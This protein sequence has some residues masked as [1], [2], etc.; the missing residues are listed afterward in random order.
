MPLPDKLFSALP[1]FALFF[2]ILILTQAAFGQGASKINLIKADQL[3]YNKDLGK[4]LRRVIGNVAFEHDGAYLYCDSAYFHEDANNV[5]AF[6][7]IHIKVSDTLNIYGD[8]L[9]YDGETK[10]GDLTGKVKLVDNQTI[11]LTDHLIWNRIEGYSYYNTGG[12]ITNKDNKLTSQIGYYYTDRKEFFF[13]KNVI[14]VNPKYTMKSD[15]LLYNTV[16]RTSFFKGPTTIK[17]ES[18]YIYCE[19]GWYN[20]IT[21]V[22]QF[23]KNGYMISGERKLWGDSLYY[24]RQLGLG[25]AFGNVSILDTVQDVVVKGNKGIYQELKGYVRMTDSAEGILVDKSGSFFLHADTLYATFD[26]ARQFKVLYAYNHTKF[27]RTDL[28][29]L[30]DSLVYNFGDSTILLHG[31]PVIWSEVNQLTADSIRMWMT[32]K[33]VDSMMLYNTSFIVSVSDTGQYDQIKGKNMIGHFIENELR[34]VKV[35]SNA[36]TIYFAKE[37][38]G[39]SIGV[40]FAKSSEMLIRMK[41]KKVY[42][43]KYVSEPDAYLNPLKETKAEEL[44][45]KGFQWLESRRPRYSGDIYKW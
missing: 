3:K 13:K 26:T 7:T 16:S 40:N 38:D 36:E 29:G 10:I 2:C 42:R 23:N 25:K 41:D 32:N 33:A 34:S 4:D 20:T 12:K 6:G 14:L 43:I 17:G 44:K 39:H 22:S 11:L 45:L 18:N 15:T 27:F 37:D 24:N 5:E 35:L 28:Q 8:Q 19:N 31:S 9:Q 21:D 1:R 30:C